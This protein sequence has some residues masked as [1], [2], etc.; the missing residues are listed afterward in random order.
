MLISYIA[1]QGIDTLTGRL[2]HIFNIDINYDMG[3]CVNAQCLTELFPGKSVA[4]DYDMVT[5]ALGFVYC[6]LNR[7]DIEHTPHRR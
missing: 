7:T 2:A 6:F 1:K 3:N 4:A 5:H